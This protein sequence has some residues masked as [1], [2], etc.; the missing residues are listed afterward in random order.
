MPTASWSSTGHITESGRHH[1]L[2][3]LGGVYTRLYGSQ[4]PDITAEAGLGGPPEAYA[5]AGQVEGG[6]YG[7]SEYWAGPVA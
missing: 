7:W 3:A 5:Y 1:D 2:L 4:N 6:A